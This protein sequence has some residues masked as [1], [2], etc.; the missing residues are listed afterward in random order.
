MCG[1]FVICQQDE[2]Q[3]PKAVLVSANHGAC[4]LIVQRT[5]AGSV[6]WSKASAERIA[7]NDELQQADLALVTWQV[8]TQIGDHSFCCNMSQLRLRST[9]PSRPM[10][11]GTQGSALAV[12]GLLLRHS[13]VQ[14]Q[15]RGHAKNVWGLE[16]LLGPCCRSWKPGRRMS[17]NASCTPS[18]KKTSG[19][20][21][22]GKREED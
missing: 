7:E 6:L 20:L 17:L 19:C 11:S 8:A 9:W 1:N 2:F 3:P 12:H 21:S 10:S 18:S 22:V 13:L 14:V 5:L 16:K 4:W 15:C